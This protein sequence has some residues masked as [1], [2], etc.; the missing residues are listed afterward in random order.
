MDENYEIV[1]INYDSREIPDNIDVLLVLHPKNL[2]ESTEGAIE[3]Y[4]LK[5]GKLIVFVDPFAEAD[6]TAPD[7]STPGVIPD[8]SSNPKKLLAKWGI[9]MASRKVIVDPS[10][11]VNVNFGTPEGPRKILYLPVPAA[12]HQS[13]QLVYPRPNG[14]KRGQRRLLTSPNRNHHFKTSDP[15]F[16]HRKLGT[17][18][19]SRHNKDR[20]PLKPF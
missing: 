11:A 18:G 6:P 17:H 19:K 2:P 9:E 14:F 8:L 15:P 20:K 13:G 10:L 1:R 4:A 5:G 16:C 12:P 7:P 3:N